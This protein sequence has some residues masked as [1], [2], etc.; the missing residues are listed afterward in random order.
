M[1]KV[2]LEIFTEE[3]PALLQPYSR[4]RIKFLMEQALREARFDGFSI[5]A[6]SSPKRLIVCIVDIEPRLPA[7]TT[8]IKGPSTKVSDKIFKKFLAS[9]HI[10]AKNCFKEQSSKGEFW[11]FEKF[12][13]TVRLEKLFPAIVLQIIRDFKWPRSMLWG[14]NTIGWSRPIRR[15]LALLGNNPICF[16]IDLK[17]NEVITNSTAIDAHNKKSNNLI[18]FDNKT[19]LSDDNETV[20]NNLDE[21]KEILTNNNIIFNQAERKAM[22]KSA[23]EK[24]TLE[25]ANKK[26]I[27]LAVKIDEKLLD[28][29]TGLVT[30]PQTIVIEIEDEL[31]DI[32]QEIIISFAQKHQKYFI[33]NSRNKLAPYF[34]VICD[35]K[36]KTLS[37]QI[38]GFAAVLKARLAD[39]KFFY[40][41]DLAR[42]LSDYDL[43]NMNFY[44]GLGTMA[45]KVERLKRLCR[46]LSQLLDK[47]NTDLATACETAA[48]YCKHDLLSTTVGEF[49]NLQGL[50]GSYILKHNGFNPNV[51]NALATYYQPL[52]PNDNIPPKPVAQILAIADK[53]D[54]IVG[55]HIKNVKATGSGDKFGLRRAAFGVIRILSQRSIPVSLKSLV[56]K[57]YE[58]YKINSDLSLAEVHQLSE[59]LF[60]ERIAYNLKQDRVA[61]K[62]IESLKA[63]YYSDELHYIIKLAH[64]LNELLA[65]SQFKEILGTYKRAFNLT[66]GQAVIKNV[67]SAFNSK[68]EESLYTSLNQSGW[69][70]DNNIKLIVENSKK[71]NNFIDSNEINH[72]DNKTKQGRLFLLSHFCNILNK[73]TN[74]DS[75]L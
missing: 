5:E 75:L 1:E 4:E 35:G 30:Y 41:S 36:K 18:T 60:S 74:F 50:L 72:P 14:D 47:N 66:K 23:I 71:I 10:Q 68:E 22:I 12:E 24:K 25:F 48:E 2:L 51:V 21:Y 59:K 58:A 61:H 7:K 6:Y 57:S 70:F 44:E 32:P 38:K 42:P 49:P 52:G 40:D 34:V 64:K 62:I 37:N 69:E 55:M 31:M 9:N 65:T 63:R 53:I 54:N 19:E 26:G 56:E 28:E 3:I 46:Y 8:R 73:V 39:G 15:G 67:P 17:K 33:T 11:F 20:I 27:E 29:V 16:I 45:D 13:P 43:T